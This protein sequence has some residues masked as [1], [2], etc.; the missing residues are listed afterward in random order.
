MKEL[1]KKTKSKITT[2]KKKTNQKDVTVSYKPL[3]L[4][5]KNLGKHNAKELNKDAPTAPETNNRGDM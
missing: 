1:L 2:K 4:S 5:R 3:T